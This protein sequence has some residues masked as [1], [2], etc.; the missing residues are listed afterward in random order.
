MTQPNLTLEPRFS[1]SRLKSPK[2]RLYFSFARA[3]RSVIMMYI[4]CDLFVVLVIG[5]WGL[6]AI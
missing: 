3:I 2:D 4:S 6:D 5:D 1:L